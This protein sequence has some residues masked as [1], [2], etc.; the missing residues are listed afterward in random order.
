MINLLAEDNSEFYIF[1]SKIKINIYTVIQNLGSSMKA[2]YFLPI[3]I[4]LLPVSAISG[5]NNIIWKLYTNSASGSIS[6]SGWG[7]GVVNS[8][9]KGVG[10]YNSTLVTALCDTNYPTGLTK[11]QAYSWYVY[12]PKTITIGGKNI[13][14][15]LAGNNNW[16]IETTTNYYS[17]IH[18]SSSTLNTDGK[19]CPGATG[20][21]FNF[22]GMSAPSIN[23]T[24]QLKDI[25][26]GN[27]A[28]TMSVP[29]A[30]IEN[31]WDRGSSANIPT[32][33][34][35]YNYTT[36]QAIP[37][38]VNIT[39]KCT[40]S[41]QTIDIHHGTKTVAEADNHRTDS[42]FSIHCTADAPATLSLTALTP[43]TESYPQ[44]IGIN[45]GSGW[46]TA[47][48]LTEQKTGQNGTEL[49]TT[50]EKNQE[51]F[52]E[53]TSVLK[54]KTNVQ[55]GQFKGSALLTIKLP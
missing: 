44:S 51:T 18:T 35:I 53:L 43:S 29:M 37:V 52:F 55:H 10:L 5:Y 25:P 21:V 23:I 39:N 12:I 13:N 48:K 22:N 46:N 27:F 8:T 30:F 49:S 38:T 54:K 40:V 33:Q 17:L 42:R 9:L 2:L 15:S 24:L 1:T 28:T 20:F 26:P 47:L 31:F 14:V 6:Y 50:I 3:A 4:S 36:P 32:P 11:N 41:T 7:T 45:L 34:T 16:Q 19:P